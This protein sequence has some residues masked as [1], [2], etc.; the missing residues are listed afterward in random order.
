M[1][2]RKK[3]VIVD[4]VLFDRKK[5]ESNF[6]KDYPMV[7][8]IA[9]M[10]TAPGTMERED[11]FYIW[12]LEGAMTVSEGDYIIEGVQGEFYPCKPDIFRQTYDFI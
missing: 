5:A 4:V 8:D 10:T 6:A 9:T 11:R 1:K 2:A 3:P 12:T 7:V